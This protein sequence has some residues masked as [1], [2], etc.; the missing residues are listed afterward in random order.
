MELK[1][2]KS[3]DI[4]LPIL[5]DENEIEWITKDGKQMKG[6]PP[7]PKPRKGMQ[8]SAEEK[9]W[10]RVRGKAHD[11]QIQKIRALEMEMYREAEN[12]LSLG[13]VHAAWNK[14]RRPSGKG[15][16]KQKSRLKPYECPKCKHTHHRGDIYEKH[17]LLF[18]EQ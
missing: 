5:Q 2:K 3:D 8:P 14:G 16:K 12:P 7:S 18:T 6:P 4:V 11:D 9:K 13:D 10:Q 17:L 1:L 15:M